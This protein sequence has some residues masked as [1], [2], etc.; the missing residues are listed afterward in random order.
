[1]IGSWRDQFSRARESMLFVHHPE[2]TRT[3]PGMEY[4]FVVPA[5]PLRHQPS[6]VTALYTVVE[7]SSQ[8]VFSMLFYVV[9]TLNNFIT[10]ALKA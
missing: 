1:M 5:L 3:P 2:T 9:I 6:S 7:T 4:G 10:V 8:Q